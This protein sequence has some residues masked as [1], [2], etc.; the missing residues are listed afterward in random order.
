MISSHQLNPI[1]EHQIQS[2]ND[3][4][5]G[6]S[7]SSARRQKRH[8]PTSHAYWL[9]TGDN[10][11][12]TSSNFMRATFT[13]T[14]RARISRSVDRCPRDGRG[15]ISIPFPSFESGVGMFVLR[16]MF[17]SAWLSIFHR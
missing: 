5:S 6:T 4:S 13:A 2:S 14:C 11:N 8:L 12:H 3:E 9:N 7:L 1:D 16:S 10:H 15:I 17:L